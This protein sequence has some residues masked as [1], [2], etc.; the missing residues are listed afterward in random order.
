M[1]VRI[2]IYAINPTTGKLK[3]EYTTKGVVKEPVVGN[4]VQFMYH[5]IQIPFWLLFL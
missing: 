3:W 1:G 5:T 2:I 4:D